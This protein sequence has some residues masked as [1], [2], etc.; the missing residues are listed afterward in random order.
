MNDVTKAVSNGLHIVVEGP[1]GAGK[2]TQIKKM[3]SFFQSFGLVANAYRN[4]GAT[5]LGQEIRKL[6]KN[7]EDIKIDRYTEQVLMAADLCA[8]LVDIVK[9]QTARGEIVISDR[10]NFVSGMIY[11][12]AGGI[13]LEQ[14]DAFHSVALATNPPLMHMLVL[15]ADYDVIHARQHHDAEGK[16]KIESRGEV[17]HRAVNA[18]YK[19]L[20]E[21]GQGQRHNDLQTRLNRFMYY[22]GTPVPSGYS[23]W[24]IDVSGSEVDVEEKIKSALVRIADLADL[25]LSPSSSAASGQPPVSG[26]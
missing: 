9:P 3:V 22:F 6:V 4:P 23:I 8:Y 2:T 14:I 5:P 21:V 17:Y 16:C 1:D 19:R 24:P 18:Q 12:L 11:S 15:H 20:V 13:N 10:S 7:R 25:V 26:S